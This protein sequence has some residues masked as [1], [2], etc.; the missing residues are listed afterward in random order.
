MNNKPLTLKFWD[1]QHGHA[2]Y[3]KTPNNKHI[4]IDLGTGR[5]INDSNEEFSPISHLHEKHGLNQI[6]L[7][8]ITHPH[9]DHIDDIL[10]LDANQIKPLQFCRPIQLLEDEILKNIREQD[11]DKFNKYCELNKEYQGNIKTR[12]KIIDSPDHCGGVLIKFFLY[13]DSLNHSN[14]NNHSIITTI[15][16]GDKKIVIPGDNEVESLTELMKDTD[17]SEAI[18]DSD[19]LL[20]P[21]H[22]R[23]SGFHKEFVETVNPKLTI[24][25]DGIKGETSANEKYSK[26]SSGHDVLKKSCKTSIKRKT[27]STNHDGRIKVTILENEL[28]ILG[29]LLLT[30]KL[31]IEIV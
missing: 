2:I 18:E 20:A 8:I 11:A 13:S 25:S 6:D 16:Y 5:K 3:I 21:H 9:K 23:E 15:E 26:L 1:V 31:N 17:F 12:D 30:G 27:L 14:F 24:I 19:I 22:G 7:L 28:P 10:N 4:V 29:N